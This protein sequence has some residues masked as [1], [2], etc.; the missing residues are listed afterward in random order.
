MLKYQRK[1]AVFR[2]HNFFPFPRQLKNHTGSQ[3]QHRVTSDRNLEGTGVALGEKELLLDEGFGWK[4]SERCSG[5]R[6]CG[7]S[8][9]G[10]CAGTR[11]GC[12]H[13]DYWDSFLVLQLSCS[14]VRL[15]VWRKGGSHLFGSWFI[16]S[17]HE[18][19]CRDGENCLETEWPEVTV[20]SVLTA[21]V[22]SC[23]GRTEAW[24]ELQGKL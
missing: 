6:G 21:V 9:W 19:L 22:N 5:E 11:R 17:P 8:W 13:W 15:C 2:Q 18:S 7:R 3:H 24:T 16:C 20:G 23:K 10:A 12:Q 14:L 4:C 1:T